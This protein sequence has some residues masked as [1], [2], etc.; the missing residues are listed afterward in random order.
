MYLI[1][2]LS[3]GSVFFGKIADTY[4]RKMTTIVAVVGKCF[5]TY[6]FKQQKENLL[7]G[8]FGFVPKETLEWIYT[9]I[10]MY[11]FRA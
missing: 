11:V 4:G 5:I 10:Y 7:H 9:V 3:S 6:I 2:T 1:L 8:P